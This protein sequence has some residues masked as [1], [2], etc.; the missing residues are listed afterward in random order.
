MLNACQY[1][2]SDLKSKTEQYCLVSQT[3]ISPK[4]K[5][6]PCVSNLWFL[7]GFSVHLFQFII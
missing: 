6:H 7:F 2:C 5:T 4:L 3:T 1:I